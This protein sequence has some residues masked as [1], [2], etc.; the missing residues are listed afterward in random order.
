MRRFRLLGA[1][2][3]AASLL[4]ACTRSPYTP[5]GTDGGSIYREACAPCHESSPG[6]TLRGLDL[7]PE[8]VERRIS[9][10]GRGMPAFPKI[11]GEARE[12]LVRYVVVMSR[13]RE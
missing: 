13:P 2:F 10:G 4:L 12:N 3:G 11:R 7:S 9:W 6:R 5:S 8:T 1:L